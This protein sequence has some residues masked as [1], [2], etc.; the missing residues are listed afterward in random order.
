[1]VKKLLIIIVFIIVF[2]SLAI[3]T[4]FSVNN[5]IS[6]DVSVTTTENTTAENTTITDSTS[7]TVQSATETSTI[8]QDEDYDTV[9]YYVA[10][11]SS[12]L[13]IRTDNSTSSSIKQTIRKGSMV[14]VCYFEGD[15]AYVEYFHDNYGWAKSEFL[16][17]VSKEASQ[18]F[19]KYDNLL[20]LNGD[21]NI[22][23]NYDVP[24]REKYDNLM[25]KF[26]SKT[27]KEGYEGFTSFTYY[28]AFVYGD[29]TDL[30]YLDLSYVNLDTMDSDHGNVYFIRLDDGSNSIDLM[31][32]YHSISVYIYDLTTNEI[33]K[34]VRNDIYSK[35]PDAK[36][37]DLYIYGDNKYIYVED[38]TNWDFYV[39][40]FNYSLI[41]KFNDED[42]MKDYNDDFCWKEG[43]VS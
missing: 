11:K 3:V 29:Y 8:K 7:T 36:S 43:Y 23:V 30:I 39:Y 27:K 15:W 10:T 24:N 22:Q 13:N 40:D 41:K 2:L 42:A 1:M 18:F 21:F 34:S 9:Y 25:T 17:K 31:C 37:H 6:K 20:E 33:G 35:Y 26:Y 12:D 5:K 32:G 16:K 19:N 14:K 38:K 4:F 28:G